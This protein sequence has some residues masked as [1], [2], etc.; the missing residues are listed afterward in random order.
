MS[1]FS[2]IGQ[3]TTEEDSTDTTQE[4]QPLEEE[5]SALPIPAGALSMLGGID[6]ESINQ[7]VEKARE[8]FTQ[9]FADG[10]EL[11][12]KRRQ[13]SEDPNAKLNETLSE[14]KEALKALA[15]K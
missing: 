10:L 4:N 7:G 3:P 14:I 15:S 5:S 2:W 13:A 9:V 1:L 8:F 12:E 6:P 11:H